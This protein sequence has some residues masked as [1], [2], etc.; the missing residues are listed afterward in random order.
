[1]K[2]VS[3]D[4]FEQVFKKTK[5]TWLDEERFFHEKVGNFITIYTEKYTFE[6]YD[7]ITKY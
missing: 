2:I 5:E 6:N 4:T 3:E 7:T 1:M